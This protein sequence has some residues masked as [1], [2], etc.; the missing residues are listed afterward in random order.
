M[1]KKSEE[2]LNQD[3]HNALEKAKQQASAAAT[4]TDRSAKI[5][6]VKPA[7]TPIETPAPVEDEYQ[8]EEK[9]EA[10]DLPAGEY[11]F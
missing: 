7:A 9:D 5:Y 1:V 2:Q 11:D 10:S 3:E 8:A 6:V 4:K